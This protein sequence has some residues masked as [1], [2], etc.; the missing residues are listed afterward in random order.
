MTNSRYTSSIR[1]KHS[2]ASHSALMENIGT[3]YY[4]G[5]TVPINNSKV[6]RQINV[7]FG[8]RKEKD[9]IA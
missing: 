5:E 9:G 3:T 8:V 7:R 2:T 1:K 6:V 4:T